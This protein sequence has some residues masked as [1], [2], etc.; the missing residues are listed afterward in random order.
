[1]WL[2]C[3]LAVIAVI[4]LYLPAS[5]GQDSTTLMPDDEYFT[6]LLLAVYPNNQLLKNCTPFECCV[7][8]LQKGSESVCLKKVRMVL[9]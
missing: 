9:L 4:L 3:N 1:M 6:K 7:D 5:I 8:I 2:C